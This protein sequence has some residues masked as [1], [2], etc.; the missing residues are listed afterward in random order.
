MSD[1]YDPADKFSLSAADA[2]LSQCVYCEHWTRGSTACKAF[3]SVIPAEILANQHDHREPW[4]D[5][6]TG[7]PGDTGFDDAGSIL[8]KP[9]PD[10]PPAAL[11]R[12]HAFIADQAKSQNRPRT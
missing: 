2:I 11:A 3:L 6:S 1:R 5:P 10:V 7:E 4:L 8:F 12:L 9:K